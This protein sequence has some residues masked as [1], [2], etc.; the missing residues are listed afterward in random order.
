[1]VRRI[2]FRFQSLSYTMPVVRCITY[3][4]LFPFVE[5]LKKQAAQNAAEYDRLAT[6]FNA[7]TGANSDKRRD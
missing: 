5:V 6:E 1:M 2:P 4:D 3:H 7:K